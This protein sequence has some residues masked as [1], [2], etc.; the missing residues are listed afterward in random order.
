MER[1]F[2]DGD[3]GGILGRVAGV[4]VDGFLDQEEENMA[5]YANRSH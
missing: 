1:V 5:W 3:K 4:R 2:E